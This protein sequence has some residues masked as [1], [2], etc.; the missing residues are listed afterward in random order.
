MI[1]YPECNIS[2][3]FL[4]LSQEC[5]DEGG[6]ASSNLTH[7]SYQLTWL[8]MKINTI[9]YITSNILITKLN[10]L[11]I[12]V[13]VIWMIYLLRVGF[14]CASS[15]QENWPPFTTTGAPESKDRIISSHQN[16]HPRHVIIISYQ[17]LV[18]A[19]MTSPQYLD[20]ALHS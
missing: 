6:L 3:M 14:C 7:H 2:A 19:A 13:Q 20:P 4:H 5:L 16:Y 8:H 9:Q 18:V 15:P 10:I 12:M 17:R 1:L 11:Y